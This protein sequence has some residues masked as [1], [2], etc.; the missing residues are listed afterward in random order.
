MSSLNMLSVQS[1]TAA[2]DW[3]HSNGRPL[4]ASNERICW[5]LP[6]WPAAR[7]G[8]EVPVMAELG[9][10]YGVFAQPQGKG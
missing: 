6:V 1:E 5:G 10:M 7:S 9:E 8:K 3:R 4:S 2:A